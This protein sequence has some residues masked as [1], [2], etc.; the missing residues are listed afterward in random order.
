MYTKQNF[1]QYLEPNTKVNSKWIIDLDVNSEIIMKVL[2][3]NI[4]ENLYD[5]VVGK[6]LLDTTLKTCSLLFKKQNK[7]ILKREENKLDFNKIKNF[8][9]KDI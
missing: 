7:T 4:G 1:D 6:D 5:L 2:E 8:S 9:L 3:E